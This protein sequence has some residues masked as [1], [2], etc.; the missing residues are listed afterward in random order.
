MKQAWA[1]CLAGAFCLGSFSMAKAQ[2]EPAHKITAQEVAEMLADPSATITYF[3]LSYRAYMDVAPPDDMNQ[4]LRLNGAGFLRLPNKTSI[5]YRGY[6]PFYSTEFPFD[7]EGVGDMLLSAYWVPS[8]GDFILGYGGALMVPTASEDYYGTDKWSAGPTLVIAKKAPG[9]YTVGGLLTHVWSFAGEDDRDEV[10]MTTIQPAM[11]FF[12][13]KKGTSVTV[14]S[15]TSYNWEADDDEWQIPVTLG[16]T[17]ILPPFG[18]FFVG[19][20]VGGTYYIEKSDYA[21][22]WDVR[23]AVSI[24]FP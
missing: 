20:G 3:N 15:E 19:V 12:L 7:D 10:S 11:T 13:N 16:V 5:L 21:P 8:K 1:V 6:L 17:Q 24:V 22:E 2:E 23:G 9:K 4:E 18:K 14:A